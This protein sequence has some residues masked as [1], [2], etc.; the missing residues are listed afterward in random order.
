[1]IVHHRIKESIYSLTKNYTQ[2]LGSTWL[3]ALSKNLLKSQYMNNLQ[4]Y[5]DETYKKS[6]FVYPRN[7]IDIFKPFKLTKATEIRVVIF[8]NEPAPGPTSNGLA[9]G[10]YRSATPGNQE[11]NSLKCSR[12]IKNCLDPDNLKD[13]KDFDCTL[14]TWAEQ[15]VLLLNISPISEYGNVM[16]HEYIFRN[17]IREVVK[18]IDS[19]SSEVVFVFT[20]QNQYKHFEKYIDRN[21]HTVLQ[22][23]G[24]DPDSSI[25]ED[26]NRVLDENSIDRTPIEW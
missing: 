22:Y 25:F 19:S 3:T 4:H 12:D 2:L 11:L 9:F 26:I 10:A 13:F 7:Q 15:Q 24:I 8:G 20:S 14:L 21:F 18:E 5:I 16:K 23:D 17:F 6:D 1:M